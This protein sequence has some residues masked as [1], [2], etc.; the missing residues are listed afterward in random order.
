MQTKIFKES[1][2]QLPLNTKK[3][4][5][6]SIFKLGSLR[7]FNFI[8]KGAIAITRPPKVGSIS[9]RTTL[10][11]PSHACMVFLT[12]P[13]LRSMAEKPRS[14]FAASPLSS[15]PDKTTMLRRLYNP[16]KFSNLSW[17][18]SLR[19]TGSNLLSIHSSS[20]HDLIT[21]STFGK[22]EHSSLLK[23]FLSTSWKSKLKIAILRIFSRISQK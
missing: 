11:Q 18:I 14:V 21:W 6:K 2:D 23:T 16:R 15:A 19:I 7:I 20:L 12:N 10:L 17:N 1:R 13:S 5:W 22:H 9:M 4:S 3:A 8:S